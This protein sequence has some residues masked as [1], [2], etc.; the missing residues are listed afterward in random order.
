MPPPSLAGSSNLE[1]IWEPDIAKSPVTE[2][3][4]ELLKGSLFRMLEKGAKSLGRRSRA[5]SHFGGL[6]DVPVLAAAEAPG[7][8][9]GALRHHL[10]PPEAADGAPQGAQA[11]PEPQLGLAGILK[12][13]GQPLLGTPGG[14]AQRRRVTEGDKGQEGGQHQEDADEPND[15][16]Q[17]VCPLRGGGTGWHW[18]QKHVER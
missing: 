18:L 3:E 13:L 10:A 15:D 1:S 14:P 11:L 5:R 2:P 4:N 7:T 6:H 12:V 16:G 17:P 8:G 9:Q